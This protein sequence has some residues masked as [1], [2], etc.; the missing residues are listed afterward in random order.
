MRWYGDFVIAC[1]KNLAAPVLRALRTFMRPN[2]YGEALILKEDVGADQA[3]GFCFQV[4]GAQLC[5][6][7]ALKFLGGSAAYAG[8][9]ELWPKLLGRN[10]F[11][12][13][14][15]AHNVILGRL[16]LRRLE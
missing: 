7:E 2:F 16:Y 9:D 12:A 8:L 5:V 1:R 15:T 13:E 10:Q 6:F 4:R 14:Q 11:Q 3:F